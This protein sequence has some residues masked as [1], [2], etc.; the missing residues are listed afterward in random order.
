[1]GREARDRHQPGRGDQRRVD[2][3]PAQTGEPGSG[4]TAAATADS[5]ESPESP[6]ERRVR[7]AK[8]GMIVAWWAEQRP[9]APA[10]VA[11]S[12]SRTFAE[13]NANANRLVRALRRRGLAVGDALALACRNRAEFAEAVYAAARGGFRLTTVNWHLTGEEA[14]YIVANCEAKALIADAAVGDMARTAAEEAPDCRVRLAVAGPIDGFEPYDAALAVEDGS[15]LDDP[16]PGSSMLYTSGTTGK[17]KGVHRAVPPGAPAPPVVNIYGYDEAGGDVHL[18]TGPLYHAAPLA[19]SLNIP[20]AFGATVVLMESWDAADTLI[21]ID[22]HGVTHTHMVPTMFHRLLSLPP[23]SRDRFSGASLRHVLHGAAPCPVPVKARLIEWLGPIVWEYY[24]ATEGVG[25]F[26]DSATWLA[27]P[28]TVGRPIADDQVVIGDDAG[29]PLPAGEIGL[30]YLKS[31]PGAAFDYFKDADKTSRSYRGDYFTLGDIGYLDADGYLFL[32]DRS[33][34]LIISGGVNIYPAEVDAVLLDHPAVGDAATIGLPDPEWGESV[35]S[36]VELQPG[37]DAS[38]ALE[39][40]LI[41]F[42]RSHLAHYKCPRRV[43]FVDQLPRQD[44]GKI[45][46]RRLRDAYQAVDPSVY[47]AEE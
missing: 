47:Q 3:S 14:G 24:A 4:A 40:E 16:V 28:G 11:P 37:I 44:N 30:V 36:V 31:P 1:M 12:G 46:K 26:V 2:M 5:P 21:L 7:L 18:C 39:H 45:Y 22:E 20:H 43:A 9:D 19:F 34:D 17:P 41:E 23:E 38:V 29:A 6:D 15:D 25:S 33:A 42:C 10:V 8:A 35:L 32:T 13:L 27:R